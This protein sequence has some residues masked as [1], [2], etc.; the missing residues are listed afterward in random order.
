M[1]RGKKGASVE[2]AGVWE[3]VACVWVIIMRRSLCTSESGETEQGAC[4]TAITQP[5]R[6]PGRLLRVA[7]ASRATDDDEDHDA[8]PHL[9]LTQSTR[10]QS[11]QALGKI[12]HTSAR[13]SG[14]A[15]GCSASHRRRH[16]IS[17]PPAP[18][19]LTQQK[20]RSL[21]PP[22]PPRNRVASLP[23]QPLQRHVA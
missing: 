15:Q 20:K 14:L 3:T 19:S 10:K 5:A 12:G 8:T 6:R 11:L 7:V 21:Y 2:V 18:H 22:L 4:T 1:Q 13:R 17:S 9:T 23:P 16:Q